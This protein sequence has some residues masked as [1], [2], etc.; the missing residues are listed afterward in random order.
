M[1]V[2]PRITVLGAAKI[3]AIGELARSPP[4]LLLEVSFGLPLELPAF[5]L[6]AW[7]WLSSVRW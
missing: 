2:S 6:M 7:N 3:L 1:S 4:L 5:A